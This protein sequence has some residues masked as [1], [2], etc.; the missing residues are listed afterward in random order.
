MKTKILLIVSLI[1]FNVK[2]QTLNCSAQSP[3][4]FNYQAVVRNSSGTVIPNQNM[5]FRINI[6]QGSPT[7]VYVY[8]EEHIATTNDSEGAGKIFT[9]DANGV[10][11]WQVPAIGSSNGDTNYIPKFISS[12]SLGNSLMFQNGARI[13]LGTTLPS[14]RLQIQADT[15]AADT[16]PLF[17]IKDKTGQTVM[18]VHQDSVHFFVK[19]DP[20]KAQNR[21]CFAVSGKSSTKALTNNYLLINPDSTRI[22]TSDTIAGFGV[23]NIGASNKT[24]YMHLT[25]KNYFIGHEAGEKTSGLYN[26]FFGFRAGKYNTTGEKNIFIG[27]NSGY[28]NTIGWRNIFIGNDCGLSNTEGNTN[29]AIG[30]QALF[31]NTIGYSNSANGYK[32]L[33]SNIDG[34]GNVA[35][36]FQ[37]LYANTSGYNNSAIGYRS[38]YTNTTGYWNT[39]TGIYALNMNT[40]GYW[41]VANGAQS[42]FVNTTGNSNTAVGVYALGG[43]TNGN[44]NTALGYVAFGEGTY[45]NSMALGYSTVITDSN[46]IRVGNFSVTSIGGFAGWTTLPSDK[47]FKKNIVENVPGLA[48]ITK[49]RPVTYNIDMDAI[50]EF[51]NTPDSLRL[52][53]SEAIKGSMLQ[54]G[55]IAQEVET[56]ANEVGF[57]FCGVD[58][59]KNK[60]DYYGLR[61]AEFTVPL[62]KAVQELNDSLKFQVSGLQL[63]NANLK[64]E[65][66]KLQTSNIKLQTEIESIKTFIGMVK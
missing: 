32:V 64:A 15:S 63:E 30:Y 33:Y 19:D 50:A 44:F 26:C 17:E 43:N 24:S 5:S 29:I 25:P 7:G 56:A 27:Y 53:D 39:A 35:D 16:E 8:S 18:V 22:Y 38:L 3:H 31:S 20:S 2:L 57:D 6:L 13:G 23:Q 4:A 40:T 60:N 62:V 34:S 11:S 37:A 36:G 10:G 21:G 47:R 61:Y 66:E 45:S 55:F 14:G 59:P 12:N 65:I 41:N 9:S 42:L 1:T 54:T 49:L 52:K 51:L 28:S 48:F 58:K 46:Q